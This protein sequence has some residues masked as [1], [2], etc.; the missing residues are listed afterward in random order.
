MDWTGILGMDIILIS[1]NTIISREHAIPGYKG[2]LPTARLHDYPG[3][4][5]PWLQKR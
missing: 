2:A 4:T 3:G 1:F 5:F